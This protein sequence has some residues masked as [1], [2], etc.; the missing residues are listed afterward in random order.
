MMSWDAFQIAE[1]LLLG[2]AAIAVLAW[3]RLRRLRS[4][5]SHAA[6]AAQDPAQTVAR[7]RHEVEELA[8]QLDALAGRIDRQVDS[9][10]EELKGLLAD[11]DARIAELRRLGGPIQGLYVP[12]PDA[13]GAD[14]LRL[15]QQGQETTEIARQLNMDIGR[16]E[17]VL[18][19]HRAGKDRQDGA[20]S[21]AGES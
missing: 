12:T 2:G 13:R 19:L 16:V 17:L 5:V 8:R 7:L 14:I 4:R 10:L 15:A 3:V 11:A 20:V 9:R 6:G 18:N 21:G 1:A